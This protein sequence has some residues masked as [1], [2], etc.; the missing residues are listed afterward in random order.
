MSEI[1]ERKLVWWEELEHKQNYKRN[2]GK[3]V[4]WDENLSLAIEQIQN[5]I[6]G[7]NETDFTSVCSR[8]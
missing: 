3:L 6:C 8:C 7:H 4:K 2:W 5:D 1:A